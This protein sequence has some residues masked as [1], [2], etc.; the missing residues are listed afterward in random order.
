MPVAPSPHSFPFSDPP[1]WGRTA[2]PLPALSHMCALPSFS[3]LLATGPCDPHFEG[4]CSNWFP[5]LLS[6][7]LELTSLSLAHFPVRLS[8]LHNVPKV[9]NIPKPIYLSIKL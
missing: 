9:A 1:V 7:S 2:A 5:S 6:C 8:R 4:S 3:P